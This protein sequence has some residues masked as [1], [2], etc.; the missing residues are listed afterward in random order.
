MSQINRALQYIEQNEEA[1]WVK[2]AGATKVT[3]KQKHCEMDRRTAEGQHMRLAAGYPLLSG[4]Q[5]DPNEFGGVLLLVSDTIRNLERHLVSKLESK[6]PA[7]VVEGSP[8]M[9]L[10]MSKFLTACILHSKWTPSW[11]GHC[12][13]KMMRLDP[14]D[15]QICGS[16]HAVSPGRFM[17]SLALPWCS[18]S[19][20][21]FR[22][23]PSGYLT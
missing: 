4:C 12:R 14:F 19:P 6:I 1:R 22:L 15:P 3:S 17:E 23:V 11:W 10:G 9:H 16:C 18:T 21:E 20:S 13:C 7:G 2:A 8:L 5:S